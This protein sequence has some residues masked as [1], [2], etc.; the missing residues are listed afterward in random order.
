MTIIWLD[1]VHCGKGIRSKFFTTFRYKSSKVYTH[2]LYV[3]YGEFD[4]TSSID[5]RHVS[6]SA[7]ASKPTIRPNW[8]GYISCVH[9]R[10]CTRFISLIVLPLSCH[11]N[12]CSLLTKC[13]LHDI[14][15]V[16]NR[17]EVDYGGAGLLNI[18][19]YGYGRYSKWHSTYEHI[20]IAGS[21]LSPFKKG[22]ADLHGLWDNSNICLPGCLARRN[23][24]KHRNYP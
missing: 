5:L 18:A 7:S 24:A 3:V 17:H 8:I 23:G 12:A 1:R 13:S 10:S 6:N 15:I 21:N 14:V 22:T 2:L 20:S 16:T 19:V 11:G 4:S 9:W